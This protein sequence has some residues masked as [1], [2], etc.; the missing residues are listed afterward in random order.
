MVQKK[1]FDEPL[2]PDSPLVISLA[3]LRANAIQRDRLLKEALDRAVEAEV[4]KLIQQQ[5]GP[6]TDGDASRLPLI[7]NPSDDVSLSDA[8]FEIDAAEDINDEDA[9]D[10]NSPAL[11]RQRSEESIAM[12]NILKTLTSPSKLSPD[13]TLAPS[14]NMSPSAESRDSPLKE[15]IGNVNAAFLNARTSSKH[16]AAVSEDVIDAHD[17]GDTVF[18]D[19]SR[20]VSCSED[21]ND[22]AN[23]EYPAFGEEV[24]IKNTGDAAL[25][26]RMSG[27]VQTVLIKLLRKEVAHLK[28]MSIEDAQLIANLKARVYDDESLVSDTEYIRTMNKKLCGG[29]DEEDGSVL[30]SR[31]KSGLSLFSED[32]EDS[33]VYTATSRRPSKTPD[34]PPVSEDKVLDVS[35][36]ITDSDA[37]KDPDMLMSII[38]NLRAEIQLYKVMLVEDSII[39]STMKKKAGMHDTDDL[40]IP[41]YEGSSTAKGTMRDYIARLENLQFHEDIGG[42]DSTG[43]LKHKVSILRNLLI[44]QAGQIRSLRGDVNVKQILN[45]RNDGDQD[46]SKVIHNE[47]ASVIRPEDFHAHD[48]VLAN[49]EYA[50]AYSVLVAKVKELHEVAKVLSE[51]RARNDEL[52]HALS[53]SR[54][55][56]HNSSE[57]LHAAHIQLAELKDHK[58]A[59]PKDNNLLLAPASDLR[60]TRSI[61]KLQSAVRGFVSRRRVLNLRQLLAAR[62]SGVL[63]ALKNTKQGNYRSLDEFCFDLFVGETGWY[64]GPDGSNFYFVLDGVT[65]YIEFESFLSYRILCL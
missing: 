38:K 48:Y 21:P 19:I 49:N 6:V 41:G 57:A 11:H 5:Q 35:P 4:G 36:A 28:Q 30:L 16:M 29:M 50:C 13:E 59:P 56:L 44:Q 43:S 2:T 12:N 24:P 9:N 37:L 60:F 40:D 31:I 45:R 32:V 18:V 3:A 46:D 62:A 52:A 22:P 61:V 17:H 54:V 1:E 42:Q 55:E 15:A 39:F 58:T 33:L 20:T 23:D 7:M 8:G 14:Y 63:Y 27:V 26:D 64:T 51:Y 25:T 47:L 34:L 65:I 53:D 10:S